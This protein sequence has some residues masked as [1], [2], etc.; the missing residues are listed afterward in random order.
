MPHFASKLAIES[1]LKEYDVPYTIIRPNYFH[2]NDKTLKPV[3]TGPGIY[4]MPLGTPGISPVDI[5]DIA[6][7]AAI[8]LTSE[9]HLGKTYNLNGP[10]VVS[11]P[12]VASIWSKLGKDIKYSGENMDGFEE[13]MRQ[14]APSW[15]AFDIRMMFQGYLERGFVAGEGDLATL[16]TLLGHP[17]AGMKT[18]PARRRKSGRRTCLGRSTRS[19]RPSNKLG[20]GPRPKARSR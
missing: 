3:L 15:S 4:P 2:Q 16:T 13:Q 6:E 9:G 17:P 20:T 19:P 10:D 7:A 18:S 8:A 14:K 11:G 5:R 1:A 12:R